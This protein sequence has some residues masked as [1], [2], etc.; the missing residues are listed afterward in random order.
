MRKI[1]WFA[2]AIGCAG[3]IDDSGG[4][5][6]DNLTPPPVKNLGPL[7]DTHIVQPSLASFAPVAMGLTEVVSL[8]PYSQHSNIDLFAVS[9]TGLSTVRWDSGSRIWSVWHHWGNPTSPVTPPQL[10]DDGAT[11]GWD[12]WLAV[13]P[14]GA[15]GADYD[16]FFA[17]RDPGALNHVATPLYHLDAGTTQ[18][19]TAKPMFPTLTVPT[20]FGDNGYY[21]NPQTA[22][23]HWNKAFNQ[24]VPIVFGTGLPR[25]ELTALYGAHGLPVIALERTPSGSSF[26]NR[27][28]PQG[29]LNAMLGPA[30]ACSVIPAINRDAHG[31]ALP[32][33]PTNLVF[34]LTGAAW[35]G[36]EETDGDALHILHDNPNDPNDPWSWDTEASGPAWT[37]SLGTLPGNHTA[38]GGA[39]CDSWYTAPP[40]SGGQGHLNVFVTTSDGQLWEKAFNGASWGSWNSHGTPP[41]LNG[42]R[43]RLTS[44]VVWF[45]GSTMHIQLFGYTDSGNG[46]PQQLVEHY[47]NGS[48]WNWGAIESA[49]DGKDLVTTSSSIVSADG[50]YQ[51]LSVFVRT[52]SGRI[53]ERAWEVN[54]TTSDWV[55]NDISHQ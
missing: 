15:A 35:E 46:L 16:A 6:S 20:G 51:R 32:T 10:L 48:S 11:P 14:S 43:W 12:R 27:G 33:N 1:I 4:S 36:D 40:V 37:A 24:N 28:L 45:V 3:G 52:A 5:V 21:F 7:D 22:L 54:G 13:A 44:Q 47:W 23:S 50:G 34:T 8:I 29:E 9:N 55:W 41:N 18:F 42:R 31:N 49:P 19:S 26:T 17:F 53:Y 25:S 38:V 30:S 39:L 2:F